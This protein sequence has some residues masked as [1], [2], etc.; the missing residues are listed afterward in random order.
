MRLLTVEHKPVWGGGQV[1][2]VNLLREW[3][4]LR[5]PIEPYVVCSPEAELEPRVRALNVPCET[6]DLGAIEK[7]RRVSWNLAQRALPT[8]LLLRLMGRVRPEVVLAN[9]AFSF[10]ASAFAAKLAGVPALW[11]EHNAT[12]PEGAVLRRMIAQ[13]NHIVVVSGA[14]EDQFLQLAPEARDKLSLIYN[15]VD[16]GQFF[17]DRDARGRKR[18]ELGWDENVMVAGTVSRLSSE[19]GITYFVDAAHE[20]LRK[21]PAT[22]FL[23]VGDGPERGELERRAGSDAIHFVGAQ[24]DVAGWLNAMDV[25]VMPSLAEGF[26]LA[27]VEAMAC[28]LPV[29]ASDVGGLREIVVENESGRRVPPRD[30]GALA[31]AV[32]ELGGDPGKCRAYGQAGR[33]RVESHFTLKRQAHAMRQVL[34]LLAKGS[35]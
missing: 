23:I 26:G 11:V 7:T 33:S 31:H 14:I 15:G 34:E 25:F 4:T 28:E 29:V 12:L 19:K 32:L 17:K 20:I 27:V 10:L 9:G 30:A 3:Q 6:I 22:R 2:L 8:A 21:E 35:S 1:A 16:V 24:K 5:A 13:A 18:R